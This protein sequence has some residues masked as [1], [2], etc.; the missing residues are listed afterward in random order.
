MIFVVERRAGRRIRFAPSAVTMVSPARM[1]KFW[2]GTK[3]DRAKVRK[4]RKSA[5]VV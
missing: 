3:L 5:P 4:P 2:I 1:P